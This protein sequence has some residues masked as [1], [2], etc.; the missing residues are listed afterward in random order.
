MQGMVVWRARLRSSSL[1]DESHF[2][3][4]GVMAAMF[5]PIAKNLFVWTLLAPVS[6]LKEVELEPRTCARGP[7]YSK[8]NHQPAGNNEAAENSN[9][10]SAGLQ[11]EASGLS[12]KEVS[13][14]HN[15]ACL[16]CC[17]AAEDPCIHQ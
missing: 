3:L 9:G 15:L 7:Q 1:P 2:F 6:R 16:L 5:Y 10:H 4:E 14:K 13:L 11:H 12:V 17:A 8:G